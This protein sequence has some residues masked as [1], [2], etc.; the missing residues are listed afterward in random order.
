M[1]RAMNNITPPTHATFAFVSR[2]RVAQLVDIG[3]R[4]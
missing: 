2:V 4:R 1:K 3:L